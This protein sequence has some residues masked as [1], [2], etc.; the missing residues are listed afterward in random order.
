MS[1]VDAVLNFFRSPYF[2]L[3]V[4]LLLLF[5]GALYLA[6][7]FW[8]Y[9]DAKRRGALAFYWALI[10]LIANF[11]GWIIYLIVRP[12]EYVEDAR[13]R[14]LEIKEKEAHLEAELSCAGC[15][16]PVGDDFLVCPYCI[17][18]LKKACINCGKPLKLTWRACPYCKSEVA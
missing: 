15:G 12:P 5:A 4:R 18:E 17:R 3:I 10:V 11:F 1:G 16:K 13:E 14:E 9:Q 7:V 6:V 2:Y 8:T